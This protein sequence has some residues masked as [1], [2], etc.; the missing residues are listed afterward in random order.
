VSGNQRNIGIVG[1]F[2]GNHLGGS[3]AH[4]AEAL[5]W[6]PVLFDAMG[7]EAR[8]RIGRSLLRRAGLRRPLRLERFGRGVA[9]ECARQNIG[10]LL[11]TGRAPLAVPELLRLRAAGVTTGVFSS[12]DPWN[13][14]Q[15]VEWYL[16]ALREDDVVFTPRGHTVPEFQAIGCVR[17]ENMPFG[18][19]ERFTV[20]PV[21]AVPGPEV[22]FVGG[23]DQD[24]AAFMTAFAGEEVPASVVGSYWGRY[25]IAGVTDLG[26]RS[27]EEVAA[28]TLAAKVNL[29]L[30]R[31]ANRDGHVM[32]TYEMAAT[33]AT[34]VVEDTADHR[35]LFGTEGEA[36]VYFRTPE[37]AAA[38]SRALLADE[39][40]RLQLRAE[41]QRRVVTGANTYRD[42]LRGML[43]SLQRARAESAALA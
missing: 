16:A 27:P 31:R 39:P 20:A 13:A 22:L 19:D 28:L 26:H 32:R 6:K 24:R 12:D 4:A 9:A 10:F 23:A 14:R 37:E 3:L 29:C 7:A 15:R 8:G 41:A 21:A 2:G 1:L 43:E 11:A 34:M 18:Y 38:K 36:V 30:V 5:G 33:G 35:A 25:P 40:L 17:V 42:R